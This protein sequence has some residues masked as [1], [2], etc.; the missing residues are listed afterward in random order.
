MSS[1]SRTIGLAVAGMALTCGTAAAIASVRTRDYFDKHVRV[2]TDL[3]YKERKVSIRNGLTLNVAEGPQGGIPLL[4]IPGQG[5][6]WQEYC[7]ALPEVTDTYHVLIVDVHGHGQSTW[8]PADY[9]GRQIADDMCAL[10]DEVFGEPAVIA[11]HS[12]GGLIAALVAARHPDLVR[13]VVFEDAPFFSTLPDRVRATYVGMDAFASAQSFLQQSSE[14][15]WVCWYMPRSYWKRV[16]GPVWSIFTR[17]V[18][19]QRRADAGRL[20]V[21]PWVGVG[22]NRIWESLSHSFDVRFTASFADNSWFRGFDQAQ[23]LSVITCPTVFLKASTRH[24]GDGNLLAALS[25]ED[26]AH[27]EELLPENRTIR[28]RSSHDI[29]FAQTKIY[30]SAL[31]EFITRL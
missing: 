10:I 2:A 4:L 17:S 30:T 23:T 11:G 16:F 14:G 1:L 13:G 3:G 12:S 5:C 31:N 8:N 28:V 29:H 6:V 26:L 19:R 21:I 25:D 15:D 20:P 22:I 9:T 18:I 7:K 27:V 24:D